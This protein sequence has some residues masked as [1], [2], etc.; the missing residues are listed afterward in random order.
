MMKFFKKKGPHL[1]DELKKLESHLRNALQPVSIR[2][3][4]LNNL[5]AR[6]LSGD[7]PTVQRQ[8]PRRLS[9]V[10]LLAGGILGSVMVLIAGIRGLVSLVFVL[11]QLIQRLSKNTQRRQPTP[12]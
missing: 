7:I 8:I 2:P 1:E 5:Q 9:Q 6:L 3:E 4:F 11:V 12:A 10:L